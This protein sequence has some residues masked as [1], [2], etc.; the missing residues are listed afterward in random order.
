[1]IRFII[2]KSIKTVGDVAREQGVTVQ[3]IQKLCKD[4]R[5]IGAIKRSGVWVIQPD[6]I[7]VPP[8]RGGLRRFIKMRK[9]G[10]GK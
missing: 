2:N 8:V 7:I 5:I 4:G 3:R 6:Y 10:G 9:P 1:M